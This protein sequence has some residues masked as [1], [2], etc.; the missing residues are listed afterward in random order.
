VYEIKNFVRMYRRERDVSETVKLKNG[1]WAVLTEY[2]VFF[3]D[4]AK[5]SLIKSFN[6][7]F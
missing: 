3:K 7:S 5:I 6:C 4:D 1:K 2:V